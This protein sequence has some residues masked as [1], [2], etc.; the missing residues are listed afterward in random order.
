MSPAL[1]EILEILFPGEEAEVAL[2]LPMQDTALPV[3]REML[4]ERADSI[5]ALLDRMAKRG[6]VFVSGRQGEERKYRLLPSIVGWAETPFWAGV[7]TD[8]ARKLA[9][10]WLRY[11]DEAFGAELARGVPPVR[12]IPISERLRESSQV[13]PYEALKAKVEAQSYCA[14]G[15]CPCRQM[16]RYVG[17][18]CDHSLENCLH[19][20]E[21]ARYMVEQGMAR[22][23]TT[24]ETLEILRK[25]NREGLVHVSDNLSEDFTSTICNCCGCCCTFLDTRK[26]TGLHTFSPSTYV[27]RVDAE[28]CRACGTCED[29]CPMGAIAVGDEDVSEVDQTLC[30]GCGVCTPTCTEEAVDLVPR[31]EIKP[32]PTIQEFVAARYKAPVA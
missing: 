3:L 20:G 12:V 14:V 31:E 17:E 9:P 19:F 21:M 8:D 32:P 26:R 23:I 4:P 27:A 5:E 24:Q 16:K 2:G 29:R 1:L 15:Y 10:L 22:E 25:A 7:P 18:G 13:L 11:R 6:T 28:L 30:I